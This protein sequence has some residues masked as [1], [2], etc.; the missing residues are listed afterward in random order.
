M[1]FKRHLSLLLSSI[2]LLNLN[3]E[4]FAVL[5]SDQGF[6]HCVDG[7]FERIKNR[8]KQIEMLWADY[9]FPSKRGRPI[10]V[11]RAAH[12]GTKTEIIG[13]VDWLRR[14]KQMNKKFYLEVPN[15]KI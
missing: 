6:Y 14:L 11:G 7:K 8:H 15:L 9:G 2:R 12:S 3:Y 4:T 13:L 1:L 5:S 10:Q